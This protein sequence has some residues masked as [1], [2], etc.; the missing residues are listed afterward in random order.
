MF[1]VGTVSVTKNSSKVVM[2]RYNYPKLIWIK[3]TIYFACSNYLA[4]RQ[5]IDNFYLHLI[6]TTEL[7]CTVN[8][9]HRFTST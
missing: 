4:N 3:Q 2:Q 9:V 7:R 6:V 8:S 1:F 5:L